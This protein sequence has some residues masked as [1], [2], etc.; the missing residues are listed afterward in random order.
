[1]SHAQLPLKSSA[2]AMNQTGRGV[3]APMIA[4]SMA[5]TWLDTIKSGPECGT[6][7]VPRR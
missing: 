7:A 1:M 4:G 5:P 3:Q 6:F 2:F